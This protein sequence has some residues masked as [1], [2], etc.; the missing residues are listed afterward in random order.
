[1]SPCAALL[2]ASYLP[3]PRSTAVT[4]QVGNRIDSMPVQDLQSK[5]EAGN[6][7]M[8][9]EAQCL[10]HRYRVN[11]SRPFRAARGRSER[12]LY[13]NRMRHSRLLR[14]AAS[15]KGSQP[16]LV[17]FDAGRAV[18]PSTTL[19][20]RVRITTSSLAPGWHEVGAV[21]LTCKQCGVWQHTNMLAALAFRECSTN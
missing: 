21:D 19:S 13:V 17:M 5:L 1:M 11:A 12:D 4:Q 14:G 6:V 9:D 15:R 18:K 7:G 8:V 16:S 2:S 3:R 10:E 20:T